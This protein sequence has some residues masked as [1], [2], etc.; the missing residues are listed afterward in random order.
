ML[1]KIDVEE[2]SKIVSR[3]LRDFY[4]EVDKDPDFE[5]SVGSTREEILKALTSIIEYYTPP[6]EFDAWKEYHDV[7]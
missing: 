6:S 2:I 7:S 4:F 3:E 1:V 5:F